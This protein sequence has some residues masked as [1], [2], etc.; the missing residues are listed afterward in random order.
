MKLKFI[1][2]SAMVLFT[3]SCKD[4]QGGEG[5]KA[6]TEASKDNDMT[7]NIN[8]TN[9]AGEKIQII[10]FADGDVAGVKLKKGDAPEKTLKAVTDAHTHNATFSDGKISWEVTNQN[11]AGEYTDE[12]GKKSVYKRD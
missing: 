12:N 2:L 1:I 11:T 6:S 3:L 8:Y 9:D 10:Y 4:T 7:T 5:A